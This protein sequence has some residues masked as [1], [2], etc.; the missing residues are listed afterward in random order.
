MS[1]HPFPNPALRHPYV[2]ISSWFIVKVSLIYYLVSSLYLTHTLA[3]QEL[4]LTLAALRSILTFPI[5]NGASTLHIVERPRFVFD[6][7]SHITGFQ[8]SIPSSVT[9]E[10]E[11]ESL[12]GNIPTLE[13]WDILWAA[14]DM[15]T[16]EMI[17]CEM[18][19]QKP[20]DLRHKCLFYIGHIP[21]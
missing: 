21:T 9:I 14:W 8:T 20:I 7:L 10:H 16:L 11:Q 15:V 2:T 5:N 3:A 12:P 6:P 1:L 4:K 19:H 13:E 18:L 17:S